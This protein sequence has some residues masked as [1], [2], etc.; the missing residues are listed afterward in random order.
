MAALILVLS[1]LLPA[2]ALRAQVKINHGVDM[3]ATGAGLF[4]PNNFIYFGHYN[5]A[6][7]LEYHLDGKTYTNRGE[8]VEYHNVD[9]PILWRIMGEEV[10]DGK[11]TLM[12][13][14]V[15]DSKPY[16][17]STTTQRWD[18]SD[19]KTWLNGAFTGSFT[20]LELGMVPSTTVYAP[21]YTYSTMA[22]NS[23]ASTA[24]V[25]VQ[26]YLPWGTPN[27]SPVGNLK[28]R[29]YWTVGDVLGAIPTDSVPRDIKGAGLKGMLFDSFFNV[30][31]WLRPQ[32]YNVTNYMLLVKSDGDL[33]I[34][35]IG[36]PMGVRPVFKLDTMN[37]LFASE[38]ME[39]PSINRVDQTVADNAG[40]YTDEDG[41]PNGGS[42]GARK[43]YKLTL[44]N[45]SLD[46]YMFNEMY[47]DLDDT[48]KLVT[49]TV[50]FKPGETL[51]FKK[52]P[53]ITGF[54]TLAYK[55]VSNSDDLMHYG[56]TVPNVD[57]LRILADDI[58]TPFEMGANSV[59][60]E[61]LDW[62][63]LNGGTLHTAYVWAQNNN[64]TQSN[65]G[66][67]PLAFTMKVLDDEVAPVLER[68]DVL[69]YPNGAN[70]DAKIKFNIKND[71]A[72][73]YYYL[74][75]P[76]SAPTSFDDFNVPANPKTRFR[77]AAA[78][79][80]DSIIASFFDNNV[81]DIYII[82]KDEV[83]NLS[84][85]LHIPINPYVAPIAPEP[86]SP[87]FAVDIQVGQTIQFIADSIATDQNL[88][89]DMLEIVAFSSINP[90]D[91]TIATLNILPAGVA[92]VYGV[93]IGKTDVD[94][95]VEDHTGLQD[96]IM[97][98]VTVREQTPDVTIEYIEEWLLNFV[99]DGYYSFNGGDTVRMT[100]ILD[101]IPEDWF[102]TTVSIVRVHT[103][104]T[105]Y[106]SKPQ[107]LYIPPRPDAPDVYG[108]KES[109]P[110]YNDGQIMDVNR[111]MEYRRDTVDEWTDV[112][113]GAV[114]GLSPDVYQVRYR[115]V[116]DVSFAGHPAYVEIEPGT[117][118][119]NLVRAVYLPDLPNVTELPA[120]GVHYAESSGDFYFAL[121]FAGTPLTVHT[122]RVID[123]KQEVLTGTLN[124]YGAYDYTITRIVG[125]LPVVIYIG[126]ETV[127]NEPVETQSVWSYDGQIYVE[128]LRNETVSVYALNGRLVKQLNVSEGIT[129]IP[130]GQG[131]YVV[132]LRNGLRRKVSVR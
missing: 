128:S 66:S 17:N 96:T 42:G 41:L 59:Y 89:D 131:V 80:V 99:N 115:A 130:V 8:V 132:L 20:P 24:P 34:D 76:A 118:V 5:H 78:G 49:D 126:P 105:S 57:S 101:S 127:G 113:Y 56:D 121:K 90:I 71:K 23:G 125:S 47:Y 88:P 16:G 1:A 72:G 46:T 32:I 109:F 119:T 15:L 86:K 75:D 50:G 114:I 11:I 54:D 27:Q 123:G 21:S 60:T 81:H 94:I 98:P 36:V 28:N 79:E 22:P 68:Y 112:E 53:F 124:A 110:F 91:G 97:V 43:A 33:N 100:T 87:A 122:N 18:N 74:I 9:A 108:V 93:S 82:A 14:Y 31:Y 48:V 6:K 39:L 102:D 69:R 25:A 13:E 73:K 29:V 103:T 7:A 67:T 117:P 62:A 2:G 30:Y 44:W 63:K 55:I 129:S 45:P 4:A 85:I 52:A 83:R 111:T 51:G 12:S 10:S 77:L 19:I 38:L 37:I 92:T 107:L 3:S 35:G 40:V 106:N 116:A 65:E 26:F 64:P 70:F 84:N 104:N 58:Y 61:N 120:P 95:V